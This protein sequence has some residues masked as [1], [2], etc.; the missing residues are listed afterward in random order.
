MA[1]E[2]SVSFTVKIKDAATAA[3]KQIENGVNGTISKILSLKGAF[4]ALAGVTAGFSLGVIIKDLYDMAAA[5][6]K[7]MRAIAANLPTGLEGIRQLRVEMDELATASGRSFEEVR[8]A[9]IEIAKLGVS[10][11]AEVL[12]RL[13]AALKLSDG[14]VTDLTSDVQGLDQVMDAFNLTAKEA[15]E[16]LAKIASAARGRTDIESVF[17]AFQGAAPVFRKLGVDVDTATKAIVA[18]LDQ[19]LKG[20][21]LRQALNEYNADGLRELAKGAKIAETA[22]ADLDK[23]AGIT[24]DGLDR[25]EQ[26]LKDTLEKRLDSLIEKTGLLARGIGVTLLGALEK[27]SS[28]RLLNAF[29]ATLGLPGLGSIV[30]SGTA[31]PATFTYPKNDLGNY[32]RTHVQTEEERKKAEADFQKATDEARKSMEEGNRELDE[33]I[34]KTEQARALAKAAQAEAAGLIATI[35]TATLELTGRVTEAAIKGIEER[36]NKLREEIVLN[37]ALTDGE[38][39]RLLEQIKINEQGE[40][41]KVL[42]D[43]STQQ[44]KDLLEY[45]KGIHVAEIGIGNAVGKTVETDEQRVQRLT[46][47]AQAIERAA[48]G[49]TQLAQAFGIVDQQAAA[50]LESVVQIAANIP[51][52]MAG[53]LGAT[54]SVAGGVASIVSNFIGASNAQKEAAARLKQAAEAFQKRS[55]AFVRGDNPVANALAGVDDQLDALLKELEGLISPFTR[56]VVNAMFPGLVDASE[57]DRKGILGDAAAKKK[58][59][60]AAD[61]FDSITEALNNLDGPAGAYRNALN[62]INKEYQQNKAS[63]IALGRVGRGA[64]SYRATV[65]RESCRTERSRSAPRPAD[66]RLARTS[67]ARSAGPER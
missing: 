22:M 7:A 3:L 45:V 9:A 24:R 36:N 39:I 55:D 29:G 21:Q 64:T 35:G 51:A 34:R 25:T 10:D 6:D 23:Q 65:G 30:G 63:A 46:N 56:G 4:G 43:K 8:N 27:L 17:E 40:K 2:K 49:A 47:M 67:T 5:A 33:T 42:D 44:K 57:A 48:R 13:S 28:P 37:T 26:R 19:G 16:V 38:K 20:K 41:Q 14:T 32:G 15:G 62:A 18:L 59:Q 52:A 66:R 11:P 60:I 53:D 12:E 1:E 61:F 58:A 50:A 54:L 31:S